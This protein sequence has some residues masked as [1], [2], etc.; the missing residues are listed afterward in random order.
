MGEAYIQANPSSF[1]PYINIYPDHLDSVLICS[2]RGDPGTRKRVFELPGRVVWTSARS[3]SGVTLCKFGAS[4]S[5]KSHKIS[6]REEHLYLLIPREVSLDAATLWMAAVDE[7]GGNTQLR[8][9]PHSL[10]TQ[11]PRPWERWPQDAQ[12]NQRI[13][14]REVQI[15]GLSPR[16][17]YSFTLK[18]NGASVASAKVRTLPEAMPLLG[19]K[20][21]TVLL[22]SCFAHHEDSERKVGNAFFHMP[23]SAAP[24]IKILAGDQVYLDSPWYRFM[25]PHASQ[26]LHDAFFEHY[27]STWSQ[28]DGFARLLIDGA[29]YF[30]SDDHEFWNN[31]PN[32]GAYVV[33]TWES[34]GRQFW[35][36]AARGL[37]SAFQTSKAIMKFSVPPVSFLFA[38]T[39]INRD[40]ERKNFMKPS[41]LDEVAQWVGNL[42]GP[43]VLVIG[44][45][46]LQTATGF[47]KGHFGD[48]NLPD[49]QAISPAR[50]DRRG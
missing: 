41:D 31:A 44:Q 5:I 1:P 11:V 24:D 50:G 28:T 3:N 32:R 30:S 38:D 36:E 12:N 45:P 37:Y 42:G 18:A 40:E 2:T 25:M 10:G 9:E 46:L 16:E 35:L 17:E 47:F 7:P 13:Q 48:W 14:Y 39:R 49:F 33:N 4:H 19:E 20:P 6:L 8:L 15:T 21:F 34:S 29:N 26:E 23:H 22:G 27:T 43:G